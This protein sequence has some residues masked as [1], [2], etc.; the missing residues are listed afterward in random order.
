MNTDSPCSVTDSYIKV[1]A[2][3]VIV[4]SADDASDREVVLLRAEYSPNGTNPK[5][6][7]K[8]LS[9]KP[10]GQFEPVKNAPDLHRAGTALQM[11]RPFKVKT[12]KYH[13]GCCVEVDGEEIYAE[14]HVC[15][16]EV[17]KDGTITWQRLAAVLKANF[18]QTME[19]VSGGIEVLKDAV[20]SP[21]SVT[22]SMKRS[23]APTTDD[24]GLWVVIKKSTDALSFNRYKTFMD[25]VMCCTRD[26][27]ERMRI[28]QRDLELR[29]PFP[30]VQVYNLLKIATEIFV[31]DNCG[32]N[33]AAPVGNIA[34]NDD[35]AQSLRERIRGFGVTERDVEDH[36]RAY[37]EVVYRDPANKNVRAGD[38]NA[39][40]TLPYLAMIRRKL[41][42]VPVKVGIDD[43]VPAGRVDR[44]Y[45]IL[46]RKLQHPCLLELIW[47]YWHEEGML[48]Q[49]LNTLSR[50]FQNRRDCGVERDPLAHLE[51]DPLRPLSNVFWG[52]IQD[53]QHRL[54]IP[55]RAGEY[56]H[57][58]GLWLDGKAVPK[59]CTVD[60]RSKFLEAFHILLYM[61]AQFFKEDD[62][63][64]VAAD[65]FPVLN[66]LREVHLLLS[67][68]AHNQYGD[69]PWTARMEMLMQQWLLARDEVREFLP[70]RVMVAYP[71][72]WMDRVDA[73]KK[74]QGWTD[75]SVLHFRDLGVYG[76]Q[77]LLSVRFG[78]WLNEIDPL[79]AANWARFW[80]AEI[81]RYVHAYRAATGVDLTS[82]PVDMTLPSVLLRRRLDTQKRP[83]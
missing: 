76:E 16:V 61:A 13:I 65:G 59:F 78:N 77:I 4:P 15:V 11:W 27:D 10:I 62:D 43:P 75:V 8:D 5:W 81:Q 49:T 83:A 35:L 72:P 54:N 66:A 70:G 20:A 31:M 34:G 28:K 12:G 58:Y 82:E 53:E 3:P 44:C 22:V 6:T 55:R 17:A 74:L 63:T 1:F 42:D 56:D 23:S 60:S 64:T 67:E 25:G 24:F 52:Y 50:R 2:S 79:R 48:V 18:D 36:W 38:D 45:G 41:G 80:R 32:V 30:G 69:L 9:G 37:R 29:L 19:R 51:F 21:K 14:T 7:A 47:S 33:I 73:V 68:G 71:E 57:H 40:A 46:H 26:L 39:V